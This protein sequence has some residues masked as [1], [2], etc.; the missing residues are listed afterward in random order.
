MFRGG[1]RCGGG[2]S[3]GVFEGSARRHAGRGGGGVL[4]GCGEVRR[5]RDIRETLPGAPS[6]PVISRGVSE[7]LGGSRDPFGS[8]ARA[9]GPAV[10]FS[11]RF[12]KKETGEAKRASVQADVC[13]HSAWRRS[14]F[15][16]TPLGVRLELDDGRRAFGWTSVGWRP[17]GLTSVGARLVRRRSA[18]ARGESVRLLLDVGRRLVAGRSACHPAV[19]GGRRALG[20][21]SMS[22]GRRP[23]G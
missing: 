17:F 19:A 20:F 18:R 10:A 16:S 12:K 13:R 21:G 14:V 22:L 5:L 3:P 8:S 4:K 9:A 15:R 23:F 2:G 11:N 6:L 7:V 1:S